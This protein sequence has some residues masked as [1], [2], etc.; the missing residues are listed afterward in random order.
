MF[1][2]Q[3][4]ESRFEMEV[5]TMSDGSVWDTSAGSVSEAAHASCCE[6]YTCSVTLPQPK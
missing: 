4:L 6:N 1:N 5:I 2:I 3:E